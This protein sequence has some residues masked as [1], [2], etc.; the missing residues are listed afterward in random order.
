MLLLLLFPIT[1]FVFEKQL[2]ER[3]IP[4]C[5][6]LFLTEACVQDLMPFTE[7]LTKVY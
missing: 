3:T 7:L 5:A 6:E 1:S 2:F 4:K